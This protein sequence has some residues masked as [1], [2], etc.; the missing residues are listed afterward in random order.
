[1]KR[2]KGIL[3]SME[4][5]DSTYR[6]VY[7]GPR[8]DNSFLP[9]EVVYDPVYWNED[10]SYTFKMTHKLTLDKPCVTIGIPFDILGITEAADEMIESL[11]ENGLDS[12][13]S[14]FFLSG[15]WLDM[16]RKNE[17]SAVLN[18]MRNVKFIDAETLS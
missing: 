17:I 11:N 12:I 1:M 4:Q 7:E 5:N 8:V 10:I 3:L 13:Y 14:T 15:R 2:L 9:P 6:K 16:P 18:R